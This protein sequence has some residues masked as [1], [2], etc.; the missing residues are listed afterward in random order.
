MHT[1]LLTL[2][3]KHTKDFAG[4]QMCDLVIFESLTYKNVHQILI[5]D[6]HLKKFIYSRKSINISGVFCSRLI[7]L[8]PQIKSC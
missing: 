4:W 1:L 5:I 8:K 3:Y 7:V 6:G 2:F